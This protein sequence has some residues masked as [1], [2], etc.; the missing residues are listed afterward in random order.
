[1][2]SRVIKGDALAV[3]RTIDSE[4]VD[5]VF[6]S[7]PYYKKR[8]YDAGGIGW[9]KT[10]EEYLEALFEV[11]DEVGRVVK[12][13]GSVWVNLADS[14]H[15]KS[16]LLIPTRFADMMRRS[17]HCIR[18]NIVWEKPP[19]PDAATDRCTYSHENLFHFVLKSSTHQKGGYYYDDSVVRSGEVNLGKAADSAR[20]ARQRIK[21]SATLT[22]DQKRQALARV[23]QFEVE[24]ADFIMVLKGQRS[25]VGSKRSR[26]LNKNGFFFMRYD[27]RGGKMGDVWR[28]CNRVGQ[29]AR[30]SMDHH[31]ASPEQLCTIPILTTCPEDGVVLDPFCGTGTT[32]AVAKKLGRS[33]VG[34]DLSSKYVRGARERISS[35]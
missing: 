28:L 9:E 21:L 12:K 35:V 32:L 27:P 1:M 15:Q 8:R 33:F 31:A 20:R 4:S 29:N 16:M 5:C 23:D 19:G 7:P 6:T 25:P 17:G 24:G 2:K 3:L 34:I 22:R 18:N 26:E 14:C 10:P 13:T 30:D 11:F